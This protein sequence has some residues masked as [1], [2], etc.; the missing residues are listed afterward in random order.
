MIESLRRFPV[1]AGSFNVRLAPA[2]YACSYRSSNLELGSQLLLAR[3][4]QF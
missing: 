4:S 3:V 1:R 2:G